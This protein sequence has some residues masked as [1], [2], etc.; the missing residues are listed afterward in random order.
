[1]FYDLSFSSCQ[2]EL[3]IDGQENILDVLDERRGGRECQVSGCV[4]KRLAL[5][6]QAK[7][8]SCLSLEARKKLLD[9][10]TFHGGRGTWQRLGDPVA[11]EDFQMD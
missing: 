5:L 1:M 2:D 3:F 11:G 4:R 6:N 10:S 7:Q 8:M 9:L